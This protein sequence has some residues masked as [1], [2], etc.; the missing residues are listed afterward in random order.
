VA[1]IPHT[2]PEQKH[3][4]Y[5]HYRQNSQSTSHASLPFRARQPIGCTL[6]SVYRSASIALSPH[7]HAADDEPILPIE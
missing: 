7:S 1:Q 4:Q 3:D 6:P 2:R 5:S